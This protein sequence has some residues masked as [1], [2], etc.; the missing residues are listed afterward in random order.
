MFLCFNLGSKVNKFM[1]FLFIASFPDSIIDFRGKLIDE[2]LTKGM[3]VHIAA[4]NLFSSKQICQILQ[5]KGVVLHQIPLARTGINPFYDFYTICYL[6]FLMIKIKPKYVLGYTLKPVIYGAFAANLSGTK[7]FPLITGLGYA[8]SNYTH[9]SSILRY[10]LVL[11]FR[12]AFKGVGD[13]FFQNPDDQ[14]LFIELGILKSYHKSLVVPGSGVDLDYYYPVDFPDTV[15]FLLAARLIGSKGVREYIEAAKLIKLSYPHTR[16]CLAGAIDI[17]KDA[18]SHHELH[19]WVASGLVDYLGQVN[20]IRKAIALSSVFVLPSY[21]REGIPRS[22]LE[23]MAMGR[24][25][26]T[27]K[28]PGCR[29]TVLD[30]QNGFF[31][32]GRSVASLVSIM[33]K[34]IV[35]PRLCEELGR[36][37]REIAIKKFDVHIVNKL[38]LQFMDIR[39]S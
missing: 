13:V 29:E 37:S 20:D 1:S 11:L 2:L 7:F 9:S 27:T 3:E 36:C 4:P 19:E 10:A 16:F 39:N 12:F 8:F 23:A 33:T 25:I 35:A 38:M 5:E 18:I 31:L 22:I 6:Y 30:G 28:M 14:S 17:S 24:P 26:I 15:V 21:Y 32:D 34:F